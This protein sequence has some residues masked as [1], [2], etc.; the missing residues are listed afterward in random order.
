MA[1]RAK[2]S[3]TYFNSLSEELLQAE[4]DS[5]AF[6]KRKPSAERRQLRCLART[7]GRNPNLLPPTKS[8]DIKS[9]PFAVDNN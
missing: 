3:A 5:A 9:V 8:T 4:V 1:L 7:V 2:T 6:R